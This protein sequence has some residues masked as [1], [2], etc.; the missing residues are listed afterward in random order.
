MKIVFIVCIAILLFAG[1]TYDK[2]SYKAWYKRCV[3]KETGFDMK[4]NY[5]DYNKGLIY[6]KDGSVEKIDYQNFD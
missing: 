4:G 1:C 2:W 5:Y 3:K 6:Y